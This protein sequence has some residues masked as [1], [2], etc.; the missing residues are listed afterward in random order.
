MLFPPFLPRQTIYDTAI[1]QNYKVLQMGLQTIFSPFF[2]CWAFVFL[3]RMRLLYAHVQFR[4]AR[5]RINSHM[6]ALAHW[7]IK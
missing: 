6:A 1:K 5:D 3:N 7:H 2:L 4:Q